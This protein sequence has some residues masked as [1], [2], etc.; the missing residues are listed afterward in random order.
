MLRAVSN[1]IGQCLVEAYTEFAHF[2][3]PRVTSSPFRPHAP[4]WG[5][6]LDRTLADFGSLVASEDY[7]LKI[8]SFV[9]GL[10]QHFDLPEICST[11]APRPLWMLNAVDP[12]GDGLALSQLTEKYAKVTKSYTTT[13]QA[14]HFA[15]LVESGRSNKAFGNWVKATLS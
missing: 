4:A 13:Q 5:L 3:P 9:F 6:D 11:I 15:L 2:E 12:K 10:L 7:N 1:S 14:D 8:A